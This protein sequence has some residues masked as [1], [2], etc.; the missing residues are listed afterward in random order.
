MIPPVQDK[1]RP[2]AETLVASFADAKLSIATAES[3][4]GG[5]I[6]ASITDIPGSSAVFDRGFVTYSNRAKIEMLGVEPT[7]LEKHGAVSEAVARQMAE[8]ALRRS[9]ADVTI[10][11]TGIAGP[12]GGSAEKPVGLVHFACA[13]RL[14]VIH[15]KMQFSEG[16]RDEIRRAC[17][18]TAFMLLDECLWRLSHATGEAEGTPPSSRP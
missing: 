16:N 11:V 12:D 3:C 5:M 13:D 17:V 2:A 14:G 9:T 7:T 8:G 10:A 1:L 18:A 4:T 15:R 6:A